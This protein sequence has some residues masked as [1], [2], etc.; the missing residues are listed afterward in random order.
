MST[1]KAKTATPLGRT[2]I[3]R[4]VCVNEFQDSRYGRGNRAKNT[5]SRVLRCTSCGRESLRPNESKAPTP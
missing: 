5:G 4:C 1:S 2:V 3:D